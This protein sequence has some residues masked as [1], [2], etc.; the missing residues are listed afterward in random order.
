MCAQDRK[1]AAVVGWSR[2]AHVGPCCARP[3]PKEH[4]C[5]L[6]A[7]V[8][9][10]RCRA[11]RAQRLIIMRASAA[12]QAR[13]A[14]DTASA[15]RTACVATVVD[16][17][18]HTFLW[19]S[20]DGVVGTTIDIFHFIRALGTRT[21]QHV[22]SRWRMRVRSSHDAL[23]RPRS[24]VSAAGPTRAPAALGLAAAAAAAAASR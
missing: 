12:I 1:T 6:G 13:D 18:D 20:D 14:T 5:A 24:Q 7:P 11:L 22:S 15:H 2:K 23:P 3:A 8:D 4:A 10:L 16:V 19:A 21:Q 17:A 9:H